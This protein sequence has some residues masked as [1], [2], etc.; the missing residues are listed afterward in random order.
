MSLPGNQA[1]NPDRLGVY[2]AVSR[3]VYETPA[4]IR[5]FGQ[6]GADAVGM[7]TVPEARVQKA[8]DSRSRAGCRVAL[9]N[10]EQI[11]IEISGRPTKLKG[12]QSGS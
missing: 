11:R 6:P 3:P 5:V 12:S 10:E 2:L 1:A 8:S 9:W 4:E 7:G